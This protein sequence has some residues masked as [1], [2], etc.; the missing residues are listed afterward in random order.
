MSDVG[1]AHCGQVSGECVLQRDGYYP[2]S[3]ICVG[4]GAILLVTFIIPTT[5]KLQCELLA[6][7]ALM[8]SAPNVCLASQDSKLEDGV[9]GAGATWMDSV[10]VTVALVVSVGDEKWMHDGICCGQ[11]DCTGLRCSRAH[12][13]CLPCTPRSVPSI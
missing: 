13:P 9:T 1:K 12:Y 4:L 10:R 5:R 2:M 7:V 6:E 8:D 3:M 11:L